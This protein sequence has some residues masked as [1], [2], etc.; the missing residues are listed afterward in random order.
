M[1]VAVM[2]HSLVSGNEVVHAWD[3][4][5]V[6]RVD[7]R[8]LVTQ[9]ILRE[10]RRSAARTERLH[11]MIEA[12]FN[13]GASVQPG[14]IDAGIFLEMRKNPKWRDEFVALGGNPEDVLART[15]AAPSY[16]VRVFLPGRKP[17]GDRVAPTPKGGR[18]VRRTTA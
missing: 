11:S 5:R 6:R 14:L 18:L 7:G 2:N 8:L 13:A 10:Y 4:R 9:R 12:A 16:C 1:A 17:R 3:G 15:E